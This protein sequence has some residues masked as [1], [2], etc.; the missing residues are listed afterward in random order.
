MS[1]EIWTKVDQYIDDLF[2][3]ADPVLEAA[4]ADS[5]K[6]GLPPIQV[7][8]NQGKLLGIFAQS[9]KA[10]SILEIGSLGGYSTIWLARA[11]APG[12]KLITLEL[13][14]KHASV[15]RANL[16]LAGLDDRAELRLGHAL[17]TLPKLVSEGAGPFDLVFI[18]ADKPNTADYFAWS[19]KLV[20][21]GSLIITDN[22][23]RNGGVADLQNAE[24]SVQGARK[25]NAAL[26]AETRVTAT[27][28]QT[29]GSKG[30]DGFAIA[31]VK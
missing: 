18:D 22:M 28:V 9:I 27:M 3:A 21:P 20:H 24:A 7:T 17:E 19:M 5:A 14:P 23:I 10:R 1:A 8:P 30:Y 15:A 4:L 11:L 26:A 12:G 29:V 2:V 13:D 25:F 6:A 31:L 16:K